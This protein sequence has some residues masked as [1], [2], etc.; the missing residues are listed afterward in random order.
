MKFIVALSSILAFASHATATVPSLGC[1]QAACGEPKVVAFDEFSRGDYIPFEA[2]QGCGISKVT[3]RAKTKHE[4]DNTDR[5]CRIFDTELAYGSWETDGSDPL[6]AA[7][8]CTLDDCGHDKDDGGYAKQNKCGDPDLV[9][10]FEEHENPGNFLNPGKVIIYDEIYA[11]EDYTDSQGSHAYPPDD[12]ADGAR[13]FIRF[14]K[15]V[16]IN[17]IE[18]LGECR[19]EEKKG[20]LAV[21]TTS[22]TI[23]LTRTSM[24]DIYTLFSRILLPDRH[25][26]LKNIRP[27]L[28][29]R[30]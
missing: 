18:F 8:S 2:F 7:S 27:I 22:L 30:R 20:Y 28:L 15:P 19:K 6:C 26:G 12:N 4:D 5:M 29:H 23:A 24:D 10:P 25:R 3:C 17:S 11:R 9:A 16:T 14:E 1:A 13:F 21:D